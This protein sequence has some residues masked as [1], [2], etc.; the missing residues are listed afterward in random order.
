[1]EKN[2][3]FVVAI[4]IGATFFSSIAFAAVPFYEGKTIRIVVGLSAGGG[5]DLW[6]R[7]IAR[8]FG[9]YIPGRPTVIVENMTGAGGLIATNYIYKA[10]KPD[11][12][13]IGHPSGLTFMNQLFEKP[14][15]EFDA[16]KFEYIG[17]PYQDDNVVF[18]TKRSGITSVDKWINAKTPVKFGGEA[19]GA[20]FSDITP[21]I[22][23]TALGFPTKV[24]LGYKGTS[25][26]KLAADSGELD[27][28]CLGW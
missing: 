14:G 15:V 9:K 16:R 23:A 2:F 22:L 27:G 8:H 17:A 18:T 10:T 6:A 20:G 3:S 25:E 28:I 7:L 4:V 11:G 26:A 21:R 5:Y 19:P 24:V 12:L 1:M 13:T